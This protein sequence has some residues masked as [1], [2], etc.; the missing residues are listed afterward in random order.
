MDG[1]GRSM[2]DWQAWN[3]MEAYAVQAAMLRT[4]SSIT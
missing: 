4:L 2:F 1:W 3:L